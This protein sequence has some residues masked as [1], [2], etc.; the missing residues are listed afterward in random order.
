MKQN[1]K[2]LTGHNMQNID[3]EDTLL[4]EGMLIQSDM[5]SPNLLRD[6]VLYYIAGFIV[7]VF[8][9]K[10][11]CIN[12]RSELLLDPDDKCGFHLPSYPAYTRFIRA[13]QEGGLVYPS[14]A[15]LKILKATEVIFQR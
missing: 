6:N 13:Q 9:T 4:A 10:L 15:V 2:G 11:E 5:E 12:C 7:N 3:D 8:L 14:Y 1:E